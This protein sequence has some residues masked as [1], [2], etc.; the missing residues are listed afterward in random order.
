M[1]VRAYLA[2]SRKGLEALLADAVLPAGSYHAVLPASADEQEEDDA[3]HVAGE[4]ALEEHGEPVVVAADVEAEGDDAGTTAVP[5]G[6]I[7]SVHLGEDLAWYAP[8]ELP[9]LV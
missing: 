1:K 7:V 2:T 3:L 8:T 4:I 9:D 5:M 6:Q